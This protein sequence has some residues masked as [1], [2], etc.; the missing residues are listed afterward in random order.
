MFDA[1]EAVHAK[2][3]VIVMVPA[4]AIVMSA[5][6]LDRRVPFRHMLTFAT[7][8]YAFTLVW[9]ST[10]RENIPKAVTRWRARS[11]AGRDSMSGPPFVDLVIQ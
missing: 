2:S 1:L 10:Q 11:P 5:L 9:L 3:L 7:H 6:T 8:F 4:F